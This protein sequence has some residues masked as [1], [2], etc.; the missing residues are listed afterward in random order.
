MV[1]PHDEISSCFSKDFVSV[2]EA[3]PPP[4]HFSH[5]FGW[6]T[7]TLVH[8]NIG[9]IKYPRHSRKFCETVCKV[10]IYV[11]CSSSQWYPLETPASPGTCIPPNICL[12]LFCRDSWGIITHKYSLVRGP[13]QGFL[14]VGVHQKVGSFKHNYCQPQASGHIRLRVR[15]CINILNASWYSREVGPIVDLGLQRFLRWW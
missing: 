2:P 14:L 7:N 8:V 3:L 13:I 6:D 1:E 10:V 15:L 5:M 12:R 4:P 11:L 9:W